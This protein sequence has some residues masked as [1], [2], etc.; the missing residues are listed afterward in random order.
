[1]IIC[2][3]KLVVRLVAC[4]FVLVERGVPY[5]FLCNREWRLHKEDGESKITRKFHDC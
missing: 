4:V 2:T 5:F 3:G 1:M